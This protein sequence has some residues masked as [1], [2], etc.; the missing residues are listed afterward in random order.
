MAGDDK[1]REQAELAERVKSMVDGLLRGWWVEEDVLEFIQEQRAAAAAE[2]VAKY[3]QEEMYGEWLRWR[4]IE[5]PCK[6]CGG[7]GRRAYANTTGWRGGISGQSITDD[8]CDKFWGSGDAQRKGPDIMTRDE[9]LDGLRRALGSFQYESHAARAITAAITALEAAPAQVEAPRAPLPVGTL[10]M[11]I[12][13][14]A[15][16][17]AQPGDESEFWADM[18]MAARAGEWIEKDEQVEAPPS[19]SARERAERWR[20]ATLGSAF[21]GPVRVAIAASL[22]AEFDQ[23]AASLRAELE[24]ARKELDC[25]RKMTTCHGCGLNLPRFNEDWTCP[26]CEM[27]RRNTETAQ[28]MRERAERAEQERDAAKAEMEQARGEVER[29]QRELRWSNR[30]LIAVSQ[31]AVR[32]EQERD[33]AVVRYSNLLIAYRETEREHDQA[34]KERDAATAEAEVQFKFAATTA[35][36]RDAALAKVAAMR[37]VVSLASLG[38]RCTCPFIDDE[39]H[40]ECCIVTQARTA[41]AEMDKEQGR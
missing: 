25:T 16:V 37:N 33:A 21:S 26:G 38:Q 18:R 36:E 2:A 40:H 4:G 8:V 23:H 30:D 28:A 34:C 10:M 14:G 12:P 9:M 35:R 24:Q 13:D 11:V 31:R 32:A 19:E 15:H 27:I 20:D 6:D 5:E 1:E 39:G 7:A 41:L 17:E 22:A 3:R 29:L